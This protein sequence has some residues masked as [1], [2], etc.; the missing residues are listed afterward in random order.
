MSNIELS[1]Q[2]IA[3]YLKHTKVFRM[4]D[5]EELEELAESVTIEKYEDGDFILKQDKTG[6]SAFMVVEGQV[7]IYSEGMIMA[8]YKRG[9]MFGELSM[10]D[11]TPYTA[12]AKAKGP[13]RV[14][15]LRSDEVYSYI[16]KYPDMARAVI[17]SLSKRLK[18][19]IIV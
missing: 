3:D 12:S 2:R 7:D 10:L 1:K 19:H 16:F 11:G 6:D 4:V 15:R 8:H 9:Q 5:H 17:S 13:V 14:I 18:R